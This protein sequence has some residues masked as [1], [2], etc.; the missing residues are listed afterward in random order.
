MTE[1]PVF[2][3]LLLRFFILYCELRLLMHISI[4]LRILT[5]FALLTS[6]Q[7]FDLIVS[8]SLLTES[9]LSSSVISI[10]NSM[11]IFSIFLGDLFGLRLR[12]SFG[13]SL[14]GWYCLKIELILLSDH[15]SFLELYIGRHFDI[16]NFGWMSVN[17][18]QF[19]LCALYYL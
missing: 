18:S 11:C 14:Y 4:C 12:L 7:N 6:K 1:S 2:S 10:I 15:E 9:V 16:L 13:K 5:T 3:D 17:V 19:F 8:D